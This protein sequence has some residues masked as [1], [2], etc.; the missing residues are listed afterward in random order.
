[1][2]AV[3]RILPRTWLA[4][5]SLV[6]LVIGGCASEEAA[7]VAHVP[8]ESASAENALI[9]LDGGYVLSNNIWNK[10][11]TSGQFAESIFRDVLDGVPV[12]GWEWQWP[13]GSDVVS[14]P[15]V[16]Y[17]NK[18][19]GPD[20]NLV[21]GFPFLVGSRKIT[22]SFDITIEAKGIY[23]MAF[24]LWTVSSLPET[25][26]K[27]VHE[28]MIWNFNNFG[29]PVGTRRETIRIDRAVYDVF[30]KESQ[31]DI[32]GRNANRWNYIAFA[33]RT[34]MLKGKLSIDKFLDYLV[35]KG[36]LTTNEFVTSVELGS[37]IVEGK[38]K[39]LVKGY[40]IS[41]E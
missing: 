27:I 37:E 18:P 40:S 14:Y 25:K 31:G 28:I 2:V 36:L 5:L 11:A 7:S 39:V 38:G 26:E 24:S 8:F 6:V 17:G 23:N 30:V 1:V 21:S 9:R 13:S 34:P 12:F 3:S 35:G 33:A 16:I 32:S 10:G 15:E 29:E 20:L 19:W 4:L 41:L 22:A